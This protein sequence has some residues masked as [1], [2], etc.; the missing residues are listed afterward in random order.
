MTNFEPTSLWAIRPSGETFDLVNPGMSS[1]VG[2]LLVEEEDS[3]ESC[4]RGGLDVC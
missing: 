1:V 3:P 2:R 4:R